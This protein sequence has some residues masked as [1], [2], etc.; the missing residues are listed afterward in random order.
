MGGA[1]RGFKGMHDAVAL[2]ELAARGRRRCLGVAASVFAL[3]GAV[4]L[5]DLL[6]GLHLLR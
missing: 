4:E 3:L 2:E 6:A 1:L 5:V